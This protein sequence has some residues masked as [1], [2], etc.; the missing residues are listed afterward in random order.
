[1]AAESTGQSFSSRATA[2]VRAGAATAA[3]AHGRHLARTHAARSGRCSAFG[4]GSG[5]A[6][7][8]ALHRAAARGAGAYLGLR[9]LLAPLKMSAAV[10]ALILIR[11]HPS[12]PRRSFSL[13]EAKANGVTSRNL[14]PPRRMCF[15][16]MSRSIPA[17]QVIR[18][19]RPTG[20]NAMQTS[21]RRF[22]KAGSAA[23]A[24]VAARRSFGDAPAAPQVLQ[25][26]G[27]GDVELLP[28]PMRDK[29]DA[30]HAFYAELDEDRLLKPFRQ[31]A[32]LPAPGDDMGGWY[33]WAPLDALGKSGDNGFA[34]CHSFG[35][36][37]SGLA[38]DYAA[39]GLPSTRDKVHR[40][41]RD[42][43]PAISEDFWRDHRFPAYT[44]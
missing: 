40:I 25:Q 1:M 41:V 29:F 42:F 26:F 3:A 34:P 24:A 21:R 4:D 28:G 16:E 44:Y 10:A 37:L 14:P 30:N 17:P 27:Y 20:G 38:R 39:T 13:Y 31:R 8:Q 23:V 15:N 32:G 43:A 6:A 2:L 5:A 35:Q 19:R 18:L 7:D 36:Y 9:H 33:S 22:L 12:S 11:G